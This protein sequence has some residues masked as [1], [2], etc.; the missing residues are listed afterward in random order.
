MRHLRIAFLLS[1]HP[2]QQAL[3][4][5]FRHYFRYLFRRLF[6]CIFRHLSNTFSNTSPNPLFNIKASC[7][8]QQKALKN[9]L[10]SV[11]KPPVSNAKNHLIS[12]QKKSNENTYPVYRIKIPSRNLILFIGQIVYL[13]IVFKH[14]LNTTLQSHQNHKKPP[15]KT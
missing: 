11:Q 8:H 7:P 9:H 10:P 2:H 1:F 4:P 14:Q 5:L 15:I 13:N 3:S 12:T 6:I